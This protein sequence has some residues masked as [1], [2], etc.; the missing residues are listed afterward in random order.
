MVYYNDGSSYASMSSTS[1]SCNWYDAS[2]SSSSTSTSSSNSESFYHT[3][4]TQRV[5]NAYNNLSN[6]LTYA[7]PAHA[8][9]P[10][11]MSDSSAFHEPSIPNGKIQNSIQF[12]NA[13]S[14]D[15]NVKTENTTLAE[16][17][18]GYAPCQG[19]QPWNFAQCYGFN[20]EP[21]C[22]LVNIIDIEDFM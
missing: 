2:S 21:A 22:P 5:S 13:T 10:I 15:A 20:D 3:K 7:Q 17:L 16:P 9:F 18:N 14:F 6:G 8:P 4:T 12:Y 11:Q 19:P 1:N